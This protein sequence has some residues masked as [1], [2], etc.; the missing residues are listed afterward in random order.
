VI[1]KN[2]DLNHDGKINLVDEAVLGQG[3]LTTYGIDTL[4][5]IADNW[6]YGT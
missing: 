4:A 6:L 3:W 5:D 1:P 2:G